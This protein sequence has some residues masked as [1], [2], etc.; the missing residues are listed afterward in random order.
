MSTNVNVN[1]GESNGI[2]AKIT[3]NY[4]LFLECQGCFSHLFKK[5]EFDEF[6]ILEEFDLLI[7]KVDIVF[8]ITPILELMRI[9]F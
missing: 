4:A 5:Y 9:S 3:K 8:S 7:N 6:R 1:V 2:V